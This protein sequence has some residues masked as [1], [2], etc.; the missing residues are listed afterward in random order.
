MA[1]TV[2]KVDMWTG[3]IDD[4]VGGL[5]VKLQPLALSVL[6]LSSRGTRRQRQIHE[7]PAGP[8]PAKST[9]HRYVS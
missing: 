2:S 9:I 1:Y 6:H 5:A 8:S 3:A 4:R 7:A